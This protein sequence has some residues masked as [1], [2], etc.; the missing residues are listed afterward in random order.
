[1]RRGWSIVGAA[2]GLATGSCTDDDPSNDVGGTQ[3]AD[4]AA[5]GTTQ[6]AADNS[7][8]GTAGTPGGA[9]DG[10]AGESGSG[11]SGDTEQPSTESL[12]FLALGDSGEGNENQYAVAAAAEAVCS[13]RGCDLALLLGDNFYDVGVTSVDDPQFADKFELAYA[14]LDMP[15]Y[16]VLGNHD[17]GELAFDWARG[18][19]QIDYG[20][21]NKKWVMPHFWYTFSSS[22]G[23][24]QFFAIDTQR[25]MFAEDLQEQR[26]W[27]EGEVAASATPW[28]VAFAHHPYI[29]NGR[30]GNAGNY[31]GLSIPTIGGQYIKEF[32]EDL[33]CGKIDVYFSGHDHNRQAFDPVCGTYFFVSGAASKTTGFEHRDRNPTT[34]EDDQRPGFT[35]AEVE[36][37][38]FTVAFYDLDGNLDHEMSFTK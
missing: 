20:A 12:R 4:T 35:W 10:S 5:T 19:Y 1:M 17:Y 37:D 23:Q 30:H 13:E 33:V 6:Q 38:T 24:T 25:V 15:F 28:R 36:G 31:E 22:S 11:S 32:V 34:W 7:G 9:S 3:A 21:V 18:Q 8:P 29:S 27:L 26:Q 2:F 14:G 16:V